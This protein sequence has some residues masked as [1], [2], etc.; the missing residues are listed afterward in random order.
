MKIG[1][2]GTGMV[3]TT[4][5]SKLVSLGHE[6]RLGSRET[7]NPKGLE[8]VKKT[9]PRASQG[10]FRSAS[11]FGEMVFV[12]LRGDVALSAVNSVG[13]ETL[14]GKI[15]V[16]VS[17]PLDVAKPMPCPLLPDLVNTNSLGEEM[18]KVLPHSAV[19]KTLNTVNCEVMVNPGL[20]K[21]DSDLFISGDD[22]SAKNK[23]VDLLRS[24]G[25]KSV[26]DL[27]DITTA[28]A[29]EMLMPIWMRMW[30]ILGTPHF[31]FKFVK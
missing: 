15:V 16:D 21:A 23:V 9:G 30:G 1:I 17:N 29:T 13:A 4:L 18:Q 12:C 19:V 3:G 11:T 25:W 2:L 14:K 31:N 22:A 26:I 5:G 24:F 28:R 20:V 6:V 8:W 10:T 7:D 27:G